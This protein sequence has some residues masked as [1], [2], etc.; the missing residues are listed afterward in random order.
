[1]ISEWMENGNLSSYLVRH[2]DADPLPLCLDVSC[3]LQHLHS[4]DMV[5]G[6]MK[7]ANVMVTIDGVAQIMDFGNTELREFTLKFTA[8]EKSCFSIRWAAPELLVGT[9]SFSKEA[10][11]YG[12]A[13]TVLEALTRR[14]PFEKL[15][16][17][18][19]LY[20]VTVGKSR[21]SRPAIQVSD[22]LWKLLEACWAET[23]SERPTSNTF[24]VQ[25][26]QIVLSPKHIVVEGTEK[27]GPKLNPREERIGSEYKPRVAYAR[28]R[29]R[30]P[31]PS[32]ST[33]NIGK[34]SDPP[35][36]A[37]P[38]RWQVERCAEDNLGRKSG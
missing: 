13:M 5:H 6:D 28:A 37:A 33:R 9:S 30:R 10:D 20:L 21:P 11:M 2:P 26:G 29:T 32:G 8:T 22:T 1:M 14:V 31:T 16:E 12:L 4:L 3:G 35:S 25:L 38:M 15:S 34:L 18:R 7:A 17:F 36:H 19:V 27:L 24:A 23:P